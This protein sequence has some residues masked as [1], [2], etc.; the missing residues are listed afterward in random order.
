MSFVAK[1][2][3]SLLVAAGFAATVGC[4][5][6]S[7]ESAG[8]DEAALVPNGA[9]TLFD[10]T[11]ACRN[12][13]AARAGFRDVDLA[14]G[15]LRWSCGDVN[16]V[17]APDLGQEYCEF[18]AVMNGKVTD[19][20]EIALGANDQV[21]CLFTS[22]F[23][24]A[25]VTDA[26][27]QSEI[28][29]YPTDPAGQLSSEDI[30]KIRAAFAEAQKTYA[31]GIAIEVGPLLH[32]ATSIDPLASTM[33]V[34]F[35]SRGAARA[36]IN[37]CANLAPNDALA[38]KAE[39]AVA[40]VDA[41]SDT[42]RPGAQKEACNTYV[43]SDRGRATAE[44]ENQKVRTRARTLWQK[45]MEL[46]AQA[47]PPPVE[48]APSTTIVDREASCDLALTTVL[49]ESKEA[50]TQTCADLK[51][52]HAEINANVTRITDINT[53][54]ETLWSAAAAAGVAFRGDDEQQR[55]LAACAVVGSAQGVGWR[56]S[57]PSICARSLR[58]A[59]CGIA[60]EPVPDALTGFELR[61]WTHRETLPIG[62]RYLDIQGGTPAAP[63]R[64]VVVCS[65]DRADVEAY[66][67]AGKRL[68]A[69]CR[70][71]FG[72][73]LA[74]Q[75]PLR[76]IARRVVP[77]PDAPPTPVRESEAFCSA[78]TGPTELPVVPTSPNGAAQ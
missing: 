52:T 21:E 59:R 7:A 54:T 14:E 42:T 60:F 2:R 53:K 77:A 55:D 1:A 78:F 31:A 47:P 45:A 5:V 38:A 28:A 9:A 43:A 16:G 73:N 29:K 33:Q 30:V 22:L 70:D 56:N 44:A 6:G 24:D 10:Q 66:S 19:G 32:N 63:F 67:R 11:L 74:L 57:D 48:G 75:V 17:T 4:T 49:P 51:Q 39:H 72:V 25:A 18:H 23:A 15:V 3:R 13:F 26:L 50:L 61:G 34:G 58:A 46:G 64:G 8:V 65:A 62:C 68:Q 12:S 41:L 27:V 69:M 36:L 71:R 35:N 40:C 20:A 76:A 37:D